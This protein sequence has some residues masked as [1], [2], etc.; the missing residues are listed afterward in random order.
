MDSLISKGKIKVTHG[1]AN[2]ETVHV[3]VTVS[4][5]D[6]KVDPVPVEVNPPR[7]TI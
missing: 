4:W 7:L 3:T 2:V 5:F 6:V 1:D